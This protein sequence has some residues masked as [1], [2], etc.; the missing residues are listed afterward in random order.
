VFHDADA[1]EAAVSDLVSAGVDRAELSLMAQEGVLEG[2]PARH[3]DDTRGAE[4]DSAA[5]RQAVYADTDVRQGRTL[6]TSMAAVVAAL[7]ASGVVVLTGGAAIPA[8]LAA[9]GAGGGAG[10]LGALVGRLAGDER[11]RFYQDQ[12]G[13]GGILLWVKIMNPAQEPRVCEI[14]KRRAAS[15]VHVHEVAA[16]GG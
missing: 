5:P 13:R 8:F 6:V 1:L 14:L 2:A 10:A 4:D 12:I 16:A 11:R 3:Y 15:D 9:A 7:A